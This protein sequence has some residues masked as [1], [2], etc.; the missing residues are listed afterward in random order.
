M[1]LWLLPRL[2]GSAAGKSTAGEVCYTTIKQNDMMSCYASELH[3]VGAPGRVNKV[4]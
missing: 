4:A 1:V 2:V 3:H